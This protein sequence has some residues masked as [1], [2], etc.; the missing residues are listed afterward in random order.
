MKRWKGLSRGLFVA[1]IVIPVA[2]GTVI[3]VLPA[4]GYFPA[5]G[6]DR[7]SLAPWRA[8]F[9]APGLATSL[10]TT[11]I[12]ALLASFFSL[13][14][15][16]FCVY[17]ADGYRRLPILRAAG[18]ILAT[19]HAALAIG[20]AFVLAPSGWLFRLW[21]WCCGPLD[22]PPDW[23][24]IQD[25]NGLALA[26]V[27]VIKETPFLILTGYAA[28]GRLG[29]PHYLQAAQALGYSRAIAWAKIVAPQ[30]FRQWRYPLLAVIAYAFSVTDMAQIVGPNAPPTFPLRILQWMNDPD[31]SLRFT[32]AAAAVLHLVLVGGF[33]L[34]G[35]VLLRL[36]G[37]AFRP[38]LSNGS[39]DF[40]R[41]LCL[42]AN[43]LL[44]GVS[45]SL[46]LLAA[47]SF[48]MLILWSLAGLW[49]FPDPWPMDMSLDHWR[50]QSGMILRIAAP[51]ILL[52]LAASVLA[53]AL[54]IALL[55]IAAGAGAALP[56]LYVPLVFPDIVFMLGIAFLLILFGIQGSWPAILWA[57]LL[58][59]FPYFYLSLA[60]S[61][62]TLDPRY[63]R[64]ARSLGAGR[65]RVLFRITLPLLRGPLAQGLAIG[66]AVSLSLY[67]PTILA[68]AGRLET[69]ATAAI[70]L[71]SAGNRHVT[72]LYAL[73]QCAVIWLAFS[74]AHR[75]GGH[76]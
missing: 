1:P 8:L 54:A 57:H 72:A 56:L 2:V 68:A 41:W 66:F 5:L 42:S 18:A 52:A 73:A 70:Q 59:V 32:A 15:A 37:Q 48:A 44:G 43:V 27:L 50:D 19:P 40:P 33:L 24:I 30:L 36:L 31:I 69:L 28:L 71:S 76:V 55:E 49:P 63:R 20:L 64:S 26:L 29:A 9:A 39:R 4:F 21:S 6:G 7:F 45:M 34:A 65:W 35:G 12:A 61:W 17:H 16:F 25:R 46:V 53:A 10:M 14:L 22:V 23:T 11:L 75:A 47:T 3:A 38:W 13:L 51:A 62:R 74:L 58:F 60:D 67:L